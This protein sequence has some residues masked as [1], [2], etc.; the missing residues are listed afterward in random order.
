MD[1][2]YLGFNF[3]HQCG[4]VLPEKSFMLKDRLVLFKL[5]GLSISKSLKTHND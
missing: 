2:I 1:D 5:P 3:I 4:N